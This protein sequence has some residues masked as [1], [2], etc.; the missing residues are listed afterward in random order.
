MY[1]VEENFQELEK[2]CDRLK[3]ECHHEDCTDVYC[4]PETHPDCQRGLDIYT[5]LVW[6]LSIEIQRFGATYN[7]QTHMDINKHFI[8]LLTVLDYH[9]EKYEEVFSCARSATVLMLEIIHAEEDLENRL[10]RI[11]W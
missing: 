4:C 7:H 3:K 9:R 1:D 10:E 6:E 11:F 2:I 5:A 8:T